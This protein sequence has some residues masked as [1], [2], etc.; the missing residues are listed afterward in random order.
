MEKPGLGAYAL[1]VALALVWGGS[2]LFIKIA[3]ET[4]PPVTL[5]LMRLAAAAAILLVA[6]RLAHQALP[7]GGHVWAIIALAAFFGNALPFTLINWGEEV[8]DSGLAAILMAGMPLFTLVAAHLVTEDEKMNRRKLAGVLCGLVGL[9]VLIGPAKLAA[10]GDDVMRQLAVAAASICYGI[11]ALII[12][13]VRHIPARAL[14]AS[15]MAV[16]V[17]MVMPV[18]AWLEA[19]WTLAPSG[20]SLAAALMLGIAQTALATLMM[21]ALIKRQGATF[22]SQINFLV[23]LIG[24]VYG[25]VFLA[26]RPSPNAFVALGIILAGIA[27]ARSGGMGAQA[28]APDTMSRN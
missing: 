9:V 5:T 19:P 20:A 1:L 18:A 26:E 14:A 3:V 16:S 22:F 17:P 13:R 6:A 21:F 2:F 15:I 24:V 10:L 8:I 11:H 12:R 27:I 28:R 4:I 23:P 7:K 25:I